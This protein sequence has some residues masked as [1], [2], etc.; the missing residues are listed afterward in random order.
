MQ[1]QRALRAGPGLGQHLRREHAHR[2]PGVDEFGGQ[3]LGDGPATLDNGGE[4]Y[5]L[6]VG[7]ALVDGLEDLSVVQ[8]RDVHDVASL[9]QRL[10]EGT[11]ARRAPLYVVEQQHFCHCRSLG[12]RRSAYSSKLQ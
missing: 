4:P 6:G 1:Q 11:D 9:R 7:G 8:V 5:L 10:G 2:E 12:M 3:L